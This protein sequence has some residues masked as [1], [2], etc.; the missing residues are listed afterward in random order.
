MSHG[1]QADPLTWAASEDTISCDKIKKG[2]S[3][4]LEAMAYTKARIITIEAN[5][6][7]TYM[8]LALY[9]LFNS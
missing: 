3:A 9:S 4:Q 2:N 7:N 5:N 1:T 6:N 8:C